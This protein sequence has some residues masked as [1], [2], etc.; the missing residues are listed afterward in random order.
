M[1]EEK[2]Q[3]TTNGMP[4]SKREL[5]ILSNPA[6]PGLLKVGL[7]TV[8]T[9]IRAA[10][11]AATAGVPAEF[12]VVARYSF[13]EEISTADLKEIEQEAHEHLKKFRYS[14]NKEFFRTTETQIRKVIEQLIT[15]HRSN[16]EL[17]LSPT[18]KPRQRQLDINKQDLSARRSP[19]NKVPIHW[20]VWQAK[21]VNGKTTELEMVETTYWSKSGARNR[22][23]ANR[24]KGNHSVTLPCEDRKCTDYGKI[25]GA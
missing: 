25:K 2:H 22:T 18:G 12:E 23:K 7:T 16:A 15:E 3:L 8:G 19:L 1:A 24:A 4:R 13:P 5:Y 14:E 6:M 11:L 10:N 21:N 9:D 17:G 20:H